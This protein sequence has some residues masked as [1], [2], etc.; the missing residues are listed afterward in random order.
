[1][2]CANCGKFVQSDDFTEDGYTFCNSLCR[3]TWRQ[4]GKPNPH[5]STDN[6]SLHKTLTDF[7]LDYSLPIPGFEDK[8][9]LIRLSYWVGPKIFIDNNKIK[10]IKKNSLTKNCEF[11]LSSNYGK[12]VNVKFKHKFLDLVPKVYIDGVEF[13]IGRQLNIW[14]YIWICL[15]LIMVFV[16]GALGSLIATAAVYSN[17]ILIRKPKN[18]FLKYMLPGITSVAAFWFYL[19]SVGY[20]MPYIESG[21]LQISTEH[22]LEWESEMLN[23]QCPI[24]VDEVT[25]LDS[26]SIRLQNT[27]CNY[28]TLLSKEKTEKDIEQLKQFLTYQLIHLVKINEQLKALR[29]K[30]VNFSYSY[31]DKN[32][33]HL[34]EITV[35]KDDYK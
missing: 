20:V 33:E 2:N 3:Y 10:P 5:I 9:V 14:E 8:E 24:M 34:F 7:N 18:K 11:I 35:T 25:R 21:M 6:E 29:E 4:N 15:P 19:Q 17:S 30:E 22:T 23:K 31:Q 16:G 32:Y 27:F 1:M 28:Y 12:T 26:S 13:E